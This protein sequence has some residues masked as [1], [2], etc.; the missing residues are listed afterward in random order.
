MPH[1]WEFEI[2]GQDVK[3]QLRPD[4]TFFDLMNI[5]CE[6]W[7]D[8]ARDGDGGVYDHLWR[9]TGA[10]MEITELVNFNEGGDKGVNAKL[11]DPDLALLLR[12]GQVDRCGKGNTILDQPRISKLLFWESA[13]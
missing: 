7:L 6:S 9:I 2:V 8:E 3:V 5:I 10:G 1:V 11:N 4:H 13:T 12:P